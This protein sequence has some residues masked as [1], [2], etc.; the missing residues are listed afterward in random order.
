MIV[1]TG[2][3][4][5]IGS[6]LVAAMVARGH[7][8]LVVC[9]HFGTDDKWRNL[10]KH[11]LRAVVAPEALLSFLDAQATEIDV[12][13]HMGAISTTTE[14]DVDLIIANNFKLSQQLWTWC[15]VRGTRFIYASS[16]ATYGAGEH[17]F[18]DHGDPVTLATLRPLN[19]YAWSKHLFDRFVARTAAHDQPVPSQWAGLKFFNVYGP[20]EYHKGSQQSVVAHLYPKLAAGE[21]ARLFKS[22]RADC[23]DGDQAR[24]FVWVGDVVAIMLW[25]F[26]RSDVSGL[27][28]A[29]TGTARSF[30]DL[31]LA[32][33]AALRREPRIEYI[34]MPESLRDKYQYFTQADMTRLRTA[35]YTEPFTALEDGVRRYVHDFLATEDAYV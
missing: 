28:N 31:A 18:V 22:Y 35:G 6:N 3:A 34:D 27:F 25:L 16:A 11:E 20:N 14:T 23:A 8:D 32:T 29:G 9:D 26:D 19:P 33:F 13:F 10:A 21:P 24:D 4:G 1:V 5:F 17:G 7:T 15:A 12:I 30:R 2:G